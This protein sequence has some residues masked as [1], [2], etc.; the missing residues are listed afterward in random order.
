MPPT[1]RISSSSTLDDWIRN[2][3]P[4]MSAAD[5]IGVLAEKDLKPLS[6]YARPLMPLGSSLAIKLAP[7]GPWVILC[8]S[9]VSSKMKGK[10]N[11]SNSFTPSGPNLANEGASI[12]TE[13]ICRASI[14]S[15]SLYKALLA[16]TSTL[17]L[18][19]VNS[20]AFLAKNSEALPLGVSTAT[21]W[22]NLMTV[23]ALTASAAKPT[24]TPSNS[25]ESFMKNLL[26][27][28]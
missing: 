23:W 7:T 3:L 4:F 22:L 10:S 20:A 1:E 11:A 2:F 25:L 6:Q 16:Y 18:P 19:L 28:K 8:R 13:P 24:T 12:C 14:S 17:T 9:A 5:L 21:T 27:T 15:L 26:E